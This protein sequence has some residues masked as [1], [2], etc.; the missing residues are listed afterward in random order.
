MSKLY[1]IVIPSFATMILYIGCSSGEY[2]ISQKKV[3]Y[4]EK[5]IIIDTIGPLTDIKEDIDKNKDLKNFKETFT[6]TVQIGAF[7]NKDNFDRF[8]SLAQQKI[9]SD[10]YYEFTGNIYKIRYGNY[11]NRPDALRNLENA[12]RL[13]YFD[14]FIIS[15]KNR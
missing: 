2:E 11:G 8:Y 6:F 10:V 9:G 1:K 5:T 13:G 14:A 3:E 4:E 15:K 7:I 12:K